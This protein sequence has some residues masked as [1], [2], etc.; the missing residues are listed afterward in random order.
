MF[1]N[2]PPDC[3]SCNLAGYVHET[4]LGYLCTWCLY[5]WPY[6]EPCCEPD[7]DGVSGQFIHQSDCTGDAR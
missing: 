2:E 5:H 3:P 4:E 6:D 1:G 7:W